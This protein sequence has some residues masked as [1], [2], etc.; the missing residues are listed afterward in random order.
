MLGPSNFSLRLVRKA[1]KQTEEFGVQSSLSPQ[2]AEKY[3]QGKDSRLSLVPLFNA[4]KFFHREVC[5]TAISTN[6]VGPGSTMIPTCQEVL[7]GQSFRSSNKNVSMR[8]LSR[9][10]AEPVHSSWRKMLHG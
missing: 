10:T 9:I 2:Q 3:L 6:R 5:N 1:L 4:E 7:S 8:V